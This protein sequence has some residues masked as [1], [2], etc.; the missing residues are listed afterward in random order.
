[1]NLR[2]DIRNVERKLGGVLARHSYRKMKDVVRVGIT[3]SLLEGKTLLFKCTLFFVVVL[4][5]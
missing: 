3:A 4:D 2:A 5:E 1:M